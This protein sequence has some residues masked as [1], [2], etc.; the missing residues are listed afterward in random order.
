MIRKLRSFMLLVG[1]TIAATACTLSP[2]IIYPLGATAPLDPSFV[3]D[4]AT[5]TETTIRTAKSGEI[6]FSQPLII[7]NILVL[8]NSVEPATDISM[9]VSKRTVELEG[10]LEFY[11]GLKVG[12]SLSTVACSF[13]RLNPG[14]KGNAKVCFIFESLDEKADVRSIDI[15]N[16]ALTSSTF[17]VANEDFLAGADPSGPYQRLMLWEPN[18]FTYK[19]TEP[20]QFRPA[21]EEERIA[22]NRPDVGLRFR[23]SAK[24]GILDVVYLS[25]NKP[26]EVQG[27]PV[28]FEATD[29]FPQT[30]EVR[31][32]KIELLALQDGIL[33]YRILTG[34][35]DGKVFIMNMPE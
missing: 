18:L 13:A 11:S 28:T 22:K 15:N 29:A 9:K 4:L 6:L 3:A 26:N 31:G 35:D 10:G 7:A 20:A 25:G 8:E 14:N 27:E 19:T 30:V 21:N 5:P 17:F 33:A 24:G 32:A 23:L 12:D 16:S 1:T 34:F 2:D